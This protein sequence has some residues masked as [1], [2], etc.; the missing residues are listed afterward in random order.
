LDGRGE[1]LAGGA[2][3]LVDSRL[4][5]ALAKPATTV[6][7]TTRHHGCYNNGASKPQ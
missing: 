1:V 2:S 5:P 3:G 6:A 4:C 7:A